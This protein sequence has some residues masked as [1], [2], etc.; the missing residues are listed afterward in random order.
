VQIH[1]LQAATLIR[2]GEE[3]TLTEGCQCILWENLRQEEV[4]LFVCYVCVMKYNNTLIF[5]IK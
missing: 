1:R 4:W 3:V 5:E 2:M